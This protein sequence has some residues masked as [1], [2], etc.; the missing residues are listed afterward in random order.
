MRGSRLEHTRTESVV[1]VCSGRTASEERDEAICIVIRVRR[2]RA[3]IAGR[4][5]VSVIIVQKRCCNKSTL[6]KLTGAAR[7]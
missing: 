3:A 6:A 4:D 1:A 2:R 5:Q 7:S